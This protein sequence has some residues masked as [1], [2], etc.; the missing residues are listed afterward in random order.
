MKVAALDLGTNSFLCL[1]AEGDASGIKLVYKDISKVVRLGQELSKTGYLHPDALE[2]ARTC[3]VEFKKEIEQFKPDRIEAVATSAARDAK[4]GNEIFKMGIEFQIPIKIISGPTEALTTFTGA[5]SGI[6]QKYEKVLLV[7]IGGG[8]TEF[9][10]GHD[11]NVL[12]FQSLD[13]GC[14]R[15]TDM[16]IKKYP[17][18]FDTQKKIK[19]YISEKS[20]TLLQSLSNEQIDRVVAVAGTPTTLAAAEL[21]EWNPEKV[22]GYFFTSNNIKRW[23]EKLAN[24]SLDEIINKYHIDKGRADIIYIGV[25]IL[26]ELLS[27]LNKDGFYVSIRGVRY[28]VALKLLK[29]D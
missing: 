20:E 25:A 23:E 17:I 9:I 22:D 4:N 7:D 2:R 10:L 28:G 29:E 5:L 6:N 11:A 26:N 3:L 18:D 24:S 14:V 8:S 16:F 19:E 13:I 21:G 27:K 15:L 1:L 12:K